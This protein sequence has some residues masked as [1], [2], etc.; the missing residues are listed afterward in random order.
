MMKKYKVGDLVRL[1]D[2]ESVPECLVGSLAL[3]S[4]IIEGEEANYHLSY[5]KSKPVY[6]LYVTDQC[7]S[8]FWEEA[9]FELVSDGE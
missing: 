3:I 4:A 7:K 6:V 1:R 9:E 5:D 8:L 2:V